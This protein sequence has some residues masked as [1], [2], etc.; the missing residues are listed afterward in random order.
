[1]DKFLTIPEE[2]YLLTVNEKTG[3]RAFLKSK[4][5]D[6]LLSAA[7]LMDLALQ[8]RIDTDIDHIIPDRMEPTGDVLLDSALQLIRETPEQQKISWWLLTLSEKA[9]R[10]REMLV[11]G[12]VEK[13]LLRMEQEHV[14]L[15]FTTKKYP[16]LI[17]DQE[18][19]EVK[20]RIKALI[21]NNDIPEFRDMVIISIAWYGGLFDL[22][23]NESQIRQYQAR[24]EQLARMDM[25]GQAVSKSM[26]K[27]THSIL[28]SIA[29]KEILGIK[30]PEEK[31]EELVEELKAL[32][33]IVNDAD[34]PE[35]VQKG[36]DQYRKTLD[37]ITKTGTNEIV[38]NTKT[39]QY[40]LK[41]SAFQKLTF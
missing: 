41:V 23:I 34:L 36:T 33:H 27:L 21:F 2:L 15:G 9:V 8:N 16:I 30:T 13:G 14:F 18:I 26:H 29:A 11:A 10:Y 17:Q 12:L 35:W 38:F 28:L 24:I 7:I 6:I 19:I 25:I 37:Y 4:K 3:R 20:S 31:L 39:G 22:F 40:G 5:F 1:M 32:M